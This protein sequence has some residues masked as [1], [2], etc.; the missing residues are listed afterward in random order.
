M[1][2]AEMFASASTNTCLTNVG[3]RAALQPCNASQN[4]NHMRCIPAENVFY[5]P[6]AAT[7]PVP[8][9][10]KSTG[11]VRPLQRRQEPDLETCRFD[12]TVS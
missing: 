12:D 4:D 1:A 2:S 9:R 8:R 7:G 6:P 3:G 11:D 10:Q 5:G